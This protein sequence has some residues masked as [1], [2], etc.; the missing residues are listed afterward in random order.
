MANPK[1]RLRLYNSY[2]FVDKDPVIDRVRT[3]VKREGLKYSEI[4]KISGVSTTTLTNWFEGKTR[5]PQY[6]TIMAVVTSLGYKQAFIKKG[7]K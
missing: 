5:R 6:C 1:G 2:N 7:S 4:E 3:L